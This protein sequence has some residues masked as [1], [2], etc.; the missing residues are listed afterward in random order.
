MSH[1]FESL[2]GSVYD[3]VLV[4]RLSRGSE[5]FDGSDIYNAGQVRNIPLGTSLQREEVTANRS[6]RHDPSEPASE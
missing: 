4:A 6:A 2:A 1:D 3:T 5:A